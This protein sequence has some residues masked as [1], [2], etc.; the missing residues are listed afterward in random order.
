MMR[1]TVITKLNHLDVLSQLAVRHV[2]DAQ[3]AVEGVGECPTVVVVVADGLA[4]EDGD[5]IW[6]GHGLD[7]F[8][9]FQVRRVALV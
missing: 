5:R 3:R 4:V 8:V 2:G 6:I 7:L 1:R 9:L